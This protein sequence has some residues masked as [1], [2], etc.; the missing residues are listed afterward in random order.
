MSRVRSSGNRATEQKLIQ[1]F[2]SAG[3]TGWRR[4]L[5]LF[6]RPDFIFPKY[7]LVLF[8]DGCF[9]HSCPW[10]GHATIPKQNAPFWEKKLNSNKMRDRAVNRVL[11]AQGWRVVRL[12]QHD[13]TAKHQSLLLRKLQRVLREPS[14]RRIVMVNSN[15]RR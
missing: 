1:L 13:L 8:V 12:W 9:W 3:I 14:A 6:G 5:P 7:R 4:K 11:R 15:R 2:R 10:P